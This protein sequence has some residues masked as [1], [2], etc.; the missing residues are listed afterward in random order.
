[1]CLHKT[2]DQCETLDE[3]LEVLKNATCSAGSFVTKVCQ[4]WGGIPRER[5]IGVSWNDFWTLM[6]EAPETQL[7]KAWTDRI[8]E[9]LSTGRS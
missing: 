7:A 2:P 6:S 9:L 3:V 1:M 8:K 5:R 4:V